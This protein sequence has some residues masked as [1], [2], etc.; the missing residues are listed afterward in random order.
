MGGFYNV[1]AF[2]RVTASLVLI[3]VQSGG[4]FAMPDERTPK[5]MSSIIPTLARLTMIGWFVGVSIAG[6]AL[7]GWWLDG[8][9]GSAPLLLVVGILLGVAVALVG[10]MRMLSDFWS[11]KR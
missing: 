9:I 2:A 6:G 1:F 4:G 3:I 7:L 5:S 8:L 11:A 10:M